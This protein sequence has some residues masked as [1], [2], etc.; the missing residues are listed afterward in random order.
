MRVAI[1]LLRNELH[2]DR[3]EMDLRELA[4]TKRNSSS[5]EEI[6]TTRLAS[7]RPPCSWV[8][9]YQCVVA[10]FD[11]GGSRLRACSAGDQACLEVASELCRTTSLLQ[12]PQEVLE[13]LKDT[14]IYTRG[15]NNLRRQNHVGQIQTESRTGA[16]I[17]RGR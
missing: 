5:T 12:I 2:C 16:S 11:G 4:V 8:Q 14:S 10:G 15:R 6:Y 7:R 17:V 3:V 13:S 1:Y 9:S